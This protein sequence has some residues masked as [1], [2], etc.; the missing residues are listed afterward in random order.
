MIKPSTQLCNNTIYTTIECDDVSD[1]KTHGSATTPIEPQLTPV[2]GAI[3]EGLEGEGVEG[4][5]LIEEEGVEENTEEDMKTKEIWM[6]FDNFCK[7]FK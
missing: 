7:C 4:E 6:D 2:E 1:G 5:E 3:P